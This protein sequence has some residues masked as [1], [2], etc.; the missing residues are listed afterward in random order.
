MPE[1]P[2]PC[3]LN[4]SRRE[5]S[6]REAAFDE[7]HDAP[8]TSYERSV[9]IGFRNGC[10]RSRR[11]TRVAAEEGPSL[12]FMRL[13]IQVY[14]HDIIR[15]FAPVSYRNS[16]QLTI[17]RDASERPTWPVPSEWSGVYVS[18][19]SAGARGLVWPA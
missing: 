16:P 14:H 6:R 13:G 9:C 5:C 18:S 4:L 19:W 17:T 10:I 11:E 15:L 7:V 12:S 3:R 1:K 8:V 2:Q